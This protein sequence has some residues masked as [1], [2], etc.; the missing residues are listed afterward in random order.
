[1]SPRRWAMNSSART[2]VLDS[3]STRSMARVGTSARMVRRREL[4]KERSTLERE[5]STREGVTRR[6]LTVGPRSERVSIAS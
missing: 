3:I 2:E 5:K 4:A 6:T 1:M